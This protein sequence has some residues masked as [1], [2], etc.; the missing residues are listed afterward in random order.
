M[1]RPFFLEMIPMAK[2]RKSK[3]EMAAELVAQDHNELD[4]ELTEV[5]QS[6]LE[7][8][9]EPLKE[10]WGLADAFL[11]VTMCG[12]YRVVLSCRSDGNDTGAEYKDG[13][14]WE[15]VELVADRSKGNHPKRYR[16]LT[17]VLDSVERFH[18]DRFGVTHL[19]SNKEVVL[20][21]AEKAGFA[22]GHR[23]GEVTK[24]ETEAENQVRCDVKVHEKD[25]RML[26]AKLGYPTAAQPGAKNKK[27]EEAWP[28]KR[29]NAKL[30]DAGWLKESE[31]KLATDRQLEGPS[32]TTFRNVFETLKDGG[33]VVVATT[34][35]E[36]QG[37]AKVA[38]ATKIKKTTASKKKVGENGERQMSC[39]DA[40]IKVLSES[41]KP[42]N[43][44]DLVEAMGR[45]GYWKSPGGKTPH[46][47]LAARIYTE[48]NSKG[49][50][51]RFTKADGGF[52]LA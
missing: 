7:W 12:R 51:S 14:T 28:V 19:K 22:A 5:D 35:P 11:W 2:Q 37:D 18:R 4:E 45:K 21:A 31:D 38:T 49:K 16:S 46:A 23:N 26:L 13:R 48:I 42:M 34:D 50:E 43:A 29:I 47:T 6:Q 25:A 17:P 3:K 32:L 10:T 36:E 15:A 33:E 1:D 20:A 24:V 9:P 8:N 52:V 40:A 41:K 27:G 39:T 30:N 44:K